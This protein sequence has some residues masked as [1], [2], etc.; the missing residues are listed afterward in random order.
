LVVIAIIGVLVALL[1]PAVQAAREA[2]RRS[3]CTNNVKQQVLA[4]HNFHDAQ[5][6][7]PQ[8]LTGCCWGTWQMLVLPFLEET[9]LNALYVDF[10]VVGGKE[11]KSEPNLTNVTSKR[12]AVASCPSDQYL[13]YPFGGFSGM[14]GGLTK[15][16]YAA[17]YGN[18]GLENSTFGQN[19]SFT[20]DLNGVKFGGAPFGY[21]KTFRFRDIHDGL[22]KT[23][24]LGEVVQGEGNDTRGLI[25]WGD[26]SGFYTYLAPNS[27]SPDVV[28]LLSDA[29]NY[30]FGQNPPC[31]QVSASLPSM[32]GAR[33][34]HPGGVMMGLC[35][36]SAFFVSDEIDL[37]TWRALST[38]K[39]AET[40]N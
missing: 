34:R 37:N 23:F 12:L 19:Y 24:L 28:Y 10:G 5:R 38:T 14:G 13:A 32:Y 25:W 30:P 9:A 1:L 8:G 39:G 31:T 27:T 33:S 35:D 4:M 21:K 20:A 36:G 22:S 2:G 11:Y 16:N 3:Q 26:A 18:T 40:I 6:H 17:N 15:H 29:C 7:L